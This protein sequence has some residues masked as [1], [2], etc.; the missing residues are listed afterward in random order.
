L[1]RRLYDWTLSLAGKPAAKVWLAFISFLESSIFPIPPDVML[2]PMCMAKRDKSFL[3]AA[4]ATVSS[5]I[6]GV[7]GYAIGAFFFLTVGQ[8]I[9]DLY[10]LQSAFEMTRDRFNEQGV[11][12]VMI[13][14]FTPLPFK[15][16]TIVSGVTTM[17]IGPFILASIIGRAGRFFSV[18]ALFWWFG[19]PIKTFI[20]KWFNLLAVA[21][22]ILLIGGFVVLKY[23]L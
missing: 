11:W 20:E 3:Y 18:A 4:I 14:G 21:F 8:S 17:P 13:A 22:V 6:G 19:A 1:L 5:I 15:I 9:I 7:A 2:M 12:W 23:L 16:I 10:G